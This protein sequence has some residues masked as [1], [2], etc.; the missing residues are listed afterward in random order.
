VIILTLFGT[1]TGL[2][3]L[4]LPLAN[5]I[6][7]LK[8]EDAWIGVNSSQLTL[9]SDKD[10]YL[11]FRRS[12]S[13]HLVTWIGLYRPIREM[14]Y[15]R[16]G[17]FYGAGAWIIDGVVDAKILIALLREMIDQVNS[18]AVQGDRFVK[19]LNDVKAQFTAPSQ[20]S[21]LISSRSKLNAG[22]KP[23][24][25][26]GFIIDPTVPLDVIE[27]AQRAS[28]ANYFSKI[29]IGTADNVPDAGQSS[30]F[31]IFPSLSMA[32]E[33]AYLRN[34]SEA[35]NRIQE[36]SQSVISLENL[37]IEN[38]RELQ[39]ITTKLNQSEI[40]KQK[41]REDAIKYANLYNELLITRSI[42]RKSPSPI[43]TYG[44]VDD[45]KVML[46]YGG[47]VNTPTDLGNL[48]QSFGN[49]NSNNVN[50]KNQK[51]QRPSN[52]NTSNN[53]HPKPPEYPSSSKPIIYEDDG[54]FFKLLGVLLVILIILLIVVGFI[55]KE[56]NCAFYGIWC[57][58]ITKAPSLNSQPFPSIDPSRPDQS[59]TELQ[60]NPQLGNKK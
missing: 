51:Y 35:R 32:I 34:I 27:W 20:V 39:I 9:H 33:T 52:N 31:K 4:N 43:N 54:K 18:I 2:E 6:P 15:D 11:I 23:E 22:V 30:T 42:T 17:S 60:T 41:F 26:S 47:L 55:F 29:L 5:N 14:G 25:E 38:E 12:V 8:L 56:K 24:G 7:P 19:K 21:S 40:S 48:N 3:L 59:N 44:L 45:D 50:L 37:K 53:I 57:K 58:P 36:L 13:G 28:S 49:S 16:A 10:S 1:T 46:G